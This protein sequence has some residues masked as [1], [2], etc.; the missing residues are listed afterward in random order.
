MNRKILMIAMLIVLTMVLVG[1]GGSNATDGATA[2]QG[3]SEKQQG[4]AEKAAAN[5]TKPA[6]SSPTVETKP[7]NSNKQAPVIDSLDSYPFPVMQGWVEQMYSV[8]EYDEGNDWEAVF[9]FDSDEEEQAVAYKKVMEDLGYETQ[10]LL[11]TVFKIGTVE[12]AGA[13][14]HGTFTF[15]I[16]DEYSEWGDGQPYVEIMFSEKK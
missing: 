1:C 10:S 2:K 5:D 16:G 12:I 8:S 13:L 6:S 7:A 4:S 11:S 15:D 9:T 14:Y 3:S